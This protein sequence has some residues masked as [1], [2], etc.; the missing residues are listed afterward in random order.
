MVL[1][2]LYSFGITMLKLFLHQMRINRRQ[3]LALEQE[4]LDV[5]HSEA[6]KP[7]IRLDSATR[8]M[9]RQGDVAH[10]AQLWVH[11]RL[12]SEHVQTRRV[13]LSRLQRLHERILV[14]E[15]ASRDVDEPRPALE[16]GEPRPVEEHGAAERRRQHDAVG[17]AQELVERGH[18]D[19]AARGGFL[20]RRLAH[21]V[22]VADRHAE[23]GGGLPR[24]DRAD[25][26]QP[27]DAEDVALRVVRCHGRVL[28]RFGPRFGVAGARG[29]G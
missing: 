6:F 14:D 26:A 16:L 5:L 22:E 13:Q 1:F 9:C 15:R 29:E 17:G 4:R 10:L 25:V 8:S 27:H 11:V 2:Y 28:M 7:P 24:D 23:G 12:V 18:E 20:P 21:D 3:R 19:G